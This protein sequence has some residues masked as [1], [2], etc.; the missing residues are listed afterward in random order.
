VRRAQAQPAASQNLRLNHSPTDVLINVKVR[1][2]LWF[3]IPIGLN[4][5]PLI[6]LRIAVITQRWPARRGYVW[7]LRVHPDVIE[8]LS[9]LRARCNERDQA[10]LPTTQWAQQREHLVDAGDQHRPQV[11]RR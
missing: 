8:D 11:M 4:V 1:Y 5:N 3:Q 7:W 10:H 9:D 2:Q 6:R